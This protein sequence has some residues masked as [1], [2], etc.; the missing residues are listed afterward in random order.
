VQVQHD[1][2]NVVSVDESGCISHEIG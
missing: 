1:A 2:R